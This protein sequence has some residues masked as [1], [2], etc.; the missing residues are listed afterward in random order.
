M[1]V[2]LAM[3][4]ALFMG[5]FSS[6]ESL[7]IRIG[8]A[9]RMV[10]EPSAAIAHQPMSR[11]F[12]MAALQPA[13]SYRLSFS[14]IAIVPANRQRTEAMREA[15]EEEP[16]GNHFGRSLASALISPN[17]WNGPSEHAR[18]VPDPSRLPRSRPL[19]LLCG[20]LLC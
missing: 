7:S 16:E 9:R 20:Q 10:S 17:L 1:P 6:T 4:V 5:T 19:F 3:F 15:E 12:R 13:A 11:P 2:V 18:P 14:S 8:D